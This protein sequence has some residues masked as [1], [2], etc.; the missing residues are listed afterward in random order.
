MNAGENDSEAFPPRFLM[1][2]VTASNY[3]LDRIAHWDRL[4]ANQRDAATGA[5]VTNICMMLKRQ[6]ANPCIKVRGLSIH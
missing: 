1:K 6:P 2:P 3:V 5:V 4:N